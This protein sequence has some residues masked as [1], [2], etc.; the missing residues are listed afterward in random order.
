MR[1]VGIVGLGAMGSNLAL[2]AAE[3]GFSVAVH[4][5]WPAA[6]DRWAA[7]APG[8]PPAVEDVA[9]FAAQLAAPRR[10]LLLLKAGEP[11]DAFLASLL[12]H[13]AAGDVVVDLGNAHYRDTERRQ[14]ELAGAGVHLLGV[15]ISGG[16]A[17]A[18]HGAA[19][20]GGGD[21][22]GWERIAPVLVALSARAE[23]GAHCCARFGPGGA[24]HFVKM[25]HNGIE[26]TEMQALA[27]G[28]LLLRDLAGLDAAAIAAAVDRWN[29]DL[30][31]SFLT[32]LAAS[33]LR[34]TE[35]GGA[36]VDRVLD[37]A[38]QKGTGRWTVEAALELG[39]YAPTLAAAV[40]ARYLSAQVETRRALAARLPMPPAREP[41]ADL[42]AALG[43]AV[44]ATRI[45]AFGQGFALLE[46]ASRAK[47]WAIDRAAVADGWRA[48]CILRSALLPVIAAA[49]RAPEAPPDPT[50]APALA[51]RLAAAE[52]PWRRAVAAALAAGLPTPA[53]AS[54][55]EAWDGLR[56]GRLGANLIAAQR[57]AFG[58][59]LFRRV[60]RPGDFHADWSGR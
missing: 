36:L 51:A 49:C 47:G 27:D 12:P 2:H 7:S 50:A 19:F 35:D 40:F 4:D 15:G 8:L 56:S 60:D 48:G 54:A 52:G 46:A 22:H 28:Y 26:Y 31:A 32:G 38:G 17:G 57:D 16:A 20:M 34:T 18:R 25:V 41:P 14:R 21:S 59:H 55:L 33:V 11:T 45:A 37:V 1:D 30:G 39:V 9:S 13:L 44:L 42:A 58:A 53:L 5:P 43:E 24:G 10:I 3:K 6:R 23:D 29:E